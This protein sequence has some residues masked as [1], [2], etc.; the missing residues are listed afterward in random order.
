MGG[1]ELQLMSIAK[2]NTQSE[3]AR[4][5]AET[6][7]RGLIAIYAPTHQRLVSAMRRALRK[8]LPTA[9]EVVY[10]YAG[11]FVISYSPNEQGY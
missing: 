6:Q 7:L 2:P 4:R 9:R 11:F 10:E 3:T 5:A 1:K 8:R